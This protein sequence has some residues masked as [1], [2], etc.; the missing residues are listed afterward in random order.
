M[1]G[2]PD[3]EA[4]TA[5]ARSAL[6]A[7]DLQ[8]AE[9][10]LLNVSENATFAVTDPAWGKGALRIHRPDYHT[11]A[12][13]ESELAWVAA[14]RGAGIVRT[15]D[16]I[17]T[18]A[19]DRVVDAVHPSGECRQAVMFEWMAG[20]E[21]EA[22]H[23]VRD[24]EELGAI[25]AR[26]HAH[27]KQWA[28]PAGF[29][30]FTWNFETSLGDNGHWG[31]WRD[32]LAVGPAEAEVLGRAAQLVNDRLTRYG[33]G[34]DRFGLIHADMRLANL[35]VDDADGERA[36]TVIDFD[37]CGFG[38]Y[39]YDLGSSLSFIEHDPQVPE[40]IDSWVRGYRTVA[41]LTAE[42]E[43]ELPT[44]VMLRRLLLV[45]WIGSHRGT[46]TAEAMGPEYTAVSVD[47]AEHYLS[48][49]S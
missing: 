22:E 43:A 48:K 31:S 5:T 37:D 27:A 47:L 34:P 15:P 11:R 28:A 26:L 4:L 35:L 21:P 14:L 23:L 49:F 46:E 29:T 24:F 44:F 19:G 12:A 2:E 39:H 30:R 17:R 38:W 18:P 25:T 36:V 42:E 10:T 8:N 41:T 40:M 20:T 33:S 7:Y 16:V 6:K 32:G 45:A 13:I 9:L 3:I 1:S